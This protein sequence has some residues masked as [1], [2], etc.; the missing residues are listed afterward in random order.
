[1]VEARTPAEAGPRPDEPVDELTNSEMTTGAEDRG[2]DAERFAVHAVAEDCR[3]GEVRR[4][5]RAWL[6]AHGATAAEMADWALIVSELVAN[7]RAASPPGTSI[8]V[9]AD[10][11][12]RRT[13]LR[14]RNHAAEVFHPRVP[15]EVGPDHLR[16]RGMLIADRLSDGLAFDVTEQVTVTCWKDSSAPDR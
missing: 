5:F 4:A 16:G 1:M 2:P 7:A 13:V 9:D 3:I 15:D 6:E 14:V 10:R 8:D 12:G 11:H